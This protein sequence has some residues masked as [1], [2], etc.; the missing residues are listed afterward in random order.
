MDVPFP[1]AESQFTMGIQWSPRALIPSQ[2][3]K[4]FTNALQSHGT[5]APA[6]QCCDGDAMTREPWRRYKYHD[7]VHFICHGY[8]LYT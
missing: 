7:G 4:E 3:V 6:A 2:P 8:T 1:F 5:Q